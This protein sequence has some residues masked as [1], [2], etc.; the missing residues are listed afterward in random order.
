[1]RVIA[2]G[3][4]LFLLDPVY[5]LMMTRVMRGPCRISPCRAPDYLVTILC[6][7]RTLEDLFWL[8]KAKQDETRET[9]VY[10]RPQC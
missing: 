7:I 2:N 8:N 10:V 5:S 1:M 6:G 3:V 9:S 4:R